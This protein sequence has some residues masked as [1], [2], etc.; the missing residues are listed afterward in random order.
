MS[1]SA[2]RNPFGPSGLPTPASRL[3]TRSLTR[4]LTGIAGLLVV[5]GFALGVIRL[6][7]LR[8]SWGEAFPPYSTFRSDPL[9]TRV[10]YE[11]LGRLPEL[12]VHRNVNPLGDRREP[13]R[14][15]VFYLGS[16]LIEEIGPAARND[17]KEP[18]PALDERDPRTW[19]TTV[20]AA[21]GRVVI[22]FHP[23]SDSPDSKRAF[24]E[25]DGDEDWELIV[26][27]DEGDE[28]KTQEEHTRAAG[29][30]RTR[31][32]FFT[33]AN[34]AQELGASFGYKT[35][36]EPT[37]EIYWGSTAVQAGTYDVPRVVSWRTALYFKDLD[38][39]WRV[40][41]RRE[42]LPVLIERSYGHGTFVLCSDSYLLSNE[43]MQ[44]ERHPKLLAWLVGPHKRVVFDEVHHGVIETPG[45]MTL[46]R[47]Y[48]LH[49][50]LAG[51]LV[52]AALF[53]WRN[54]I[55]FVPSDEAIGQA[56]QPFQAANVQT[57]EGRDFA[58]GLV[59]LLRRNIAVRD[60]LR[61]CFEEWQRAFAH[62]GTRAADVAP[63]LQSLLDQS[64]G[65]TA[66]ATD[67]AA[68]YR[69]MSH[70]VTERK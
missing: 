49:G 25:D 23:V 5:T 8:F 42:G 26:K 59:N 47:K 54:A 44:Q 40:V 13:A 55:S 28:E 16:S 51:L 46:A 57:L 1:T 7:A 34:F 10:L 56:G 19:L 53:V 48:R 29:P 39:A 50:F 62:G 63:R 4:R 58:I 21:G 17:E 18:E 30:A 14:T 2:T 36:L 66:A 20:A 33:M 69:R 24:W 27:D 70:V 35:P 3:S 9:G 65:D 67:P 52:V 68:T 60:V 11:S 6:F 61:V 45:M 41:Y 12:T 31:R 32:G 38:T 64:A 37:G 43:A 22:S 15:T